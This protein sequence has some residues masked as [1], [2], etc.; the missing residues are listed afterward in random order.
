V[1]IQAAVD[2]Q[3]ADDHAKDERGKASHGVSLR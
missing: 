2:Q 1:V 3:T